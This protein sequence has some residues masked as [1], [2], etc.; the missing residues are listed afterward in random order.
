M[1]END[2][3][4]NSKTKRIMNKNATQP[5]HC[6]RWSSENY[7]HCVVYICKS[8]VF[9]LSSGRYALDLSQLLPLLKRGWRNR[10]PAPDC[11]LG[12]VAILQDN[13]RSFEL[14][15]GSTTINACDYIPRLSC[16]MRFEEPQSKILSLLDSFSHS[17]LYRN[18][19]KDP[20]HDF[21][22]RWWF[23]KQINMKKIIIR[24]NWIMTNCIFRVR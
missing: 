22:R 23:F 2:S 15:T 8:A 24:I 6:F 7:L 18:L 12:Y 11:C 9:P 21:N 19:F 16:Y 20:S 3:K 13:L 5:H 14:P 1:K 4:L 10:C 17:V